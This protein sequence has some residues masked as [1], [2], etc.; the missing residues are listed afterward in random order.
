MPIKE[1]LR[2]RTVRISAAVVNEAGAATDPSICVLH[3]RS[4]DGTETSYTYGTD[5]E[6]QRDSLGHFSADFVLEDAG[7]YEYL[8]Q[9]VNPTGVDEG[10]FQVVQGAFS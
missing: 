1:Y 3:L 5:P 8:W 4:P 7:R 9:T 6:V 2:G 10:R